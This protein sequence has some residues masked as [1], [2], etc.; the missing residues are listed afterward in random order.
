MLSRKYEQML[1][2]IWIGWF[3]VLGVTEAICS[4]VDIGADHFGFIVTDTAATAFYIGAATIA[5]F[6]VKAVV[7]NTRDFRTASQVTT[8]EWEKAMRRLKR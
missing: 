1:L 5:G 6:G 4:V 7:R 3:C 2:L 8:E